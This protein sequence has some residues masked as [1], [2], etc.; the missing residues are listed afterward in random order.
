M[1]ETVRLFCNGFLLA[2][3]NV[4]GKSTMNR[5]C[6]PAR[7]REREREMKLAP[8][9]QDAKQLKTAAKDKS[10]DAATWQ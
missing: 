8:F 10:D 9:W 7:E 5:T 2:L 4:M 1:G 6:S 3:A